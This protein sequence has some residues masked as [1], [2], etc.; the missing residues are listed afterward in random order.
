VLRSVSGTL[1]SVTPT[2]TGKAKYMSALEGTTSG[3]IR[4]KM[5][6]VQRGI[7]AATVAAAF[8][9]VMGGSASAAP[10][11]Q[12][13]AS[14]TANVVVASGI[15]LLTGLTPSFTLS[16]PPGT[17]VTGT[18]AVKFN[19]ETNNVAGYAV[20]VQSA[21]PDLLPPSPTNPDVIPIA[22]L[23]VKEDSATYTPLSSTTT[24]T[25]HSQANRSVSG[26]DALTN[27]FQIRIPLVNAD[28]YHATLNY[29]ATT[30]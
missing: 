21:N 12:S 8:T 15:T 9:G 6:L 3:P 1:L 20:T 5:R 10:G 26:G 19:V 18:D 4:P 24:V 13:A 23:T 27:D 28:T 14:T 11:G 17:V 16:G 25:V 2:L 29:I 7:V 30:L 22:D